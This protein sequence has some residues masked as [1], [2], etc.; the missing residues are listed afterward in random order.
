MLKKELLQ[1]IKPPKSGKTTSPTW[2]FLLFKT[3]ELYRMQLEY[4]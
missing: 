1:A 4:W 2:W 3:K